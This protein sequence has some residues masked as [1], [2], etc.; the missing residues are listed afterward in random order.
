V[1]FALRENSYDELEKML[2]EAEL[3]MQGLELPYKVMELCTGDLGFAASKTYDIEAWVPSQE[4]Y[5][6]V[7]SVSNCEAFQARRANIRVRR[8][9]GLEFAHTLN[10]SGVALPR[11]LVSFVENHQEGKGIRVPKAL[12]PYM[13]TDYIGLE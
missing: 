2:E 12:Q 5:R 11:T 4:R 10:G 8:K 6:E 7:S 9:E 1:K 3:V 13:E